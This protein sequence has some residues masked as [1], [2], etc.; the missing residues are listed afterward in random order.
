MV[1]IANFVF[2]KIT[3]ETHS[4][5]SLPETFWRKKTSQTPKRI[6]NHHFPQKWVGKKIFPPSPH[7]KHR[8]FRFPNSHPQHPPRNSQPTAPMELPIVEAT[9]L[10]VVLWGGLWSPGKIYHFHAGSTR[11]AK[12]TYYHQTFQVPSKW[13]NPHRHI[14]CMDTAYVRE[15]SHPQ[16]GHP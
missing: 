11:I 9:A 16:N 4:E 12:I 1:G 8:D 15:F 5:S 13:R 3:S 6:L 14:S 7:F 10:D 2:R